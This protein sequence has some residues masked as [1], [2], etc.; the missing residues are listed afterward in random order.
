MPKF[1]LLTVLTAILYICPVYAQS[2]LPEVY[3]VKV[4]TSLTQKLNWPYAQLLEDTTGKL[5]IDDVSAM[6]LSGKF[7]Q[8]NTDKTGLNKRVKFYWQRFDLR[9]VTDRSVRIVIPAR[10]PRTDFYMQLHGGKWKKQTSGWQ[11]DYK[12]RDGFKDEMYVYYELI[13]GQE[14]VFYEHTKVSL[15]PAGPK[16][17]GISIGFYDPFVKVNYIKTGEHF[18]GAVKYSFLFGFM[19]LAA[20]INLIFYFLVKDRLYLYFA[21]VVLVLGFM[22]WLPEINDIFFGDWPY[23]KYTHLLLLCLF[24]FFLW[25]LIN[26]FFEFYLHFP[27]LSKW[28]TALNAL[29]TMAQ[30]LNFFQITVVLSLW[31]LGIYY[32]LL[33]VIVVVCLFNTKTAS[34][35]R[36]IVIMPF[37]L[38]IVLAIAFNFLF[39]RFGIRIFGPDKLFIAAMCCMVA[40]FLWILLDRLLTTIRQGETARLKLVEEQ[41]VLLEAKVTERTIELSTSL[42]SLKSAQRQLI[43]AEKMA[44]LGEL[45]A[46]IAHEIQNPLN[47]INNFSE[48]NTELIEEMNAELK[49]GNIEEGILIASDIEVNM[50]KIN[51]HGKRADA[52]VKGM[53]AHSRTSTGAKE[54]TD[55]NTL[56]D[57]YL[58]LTYH[59]LRAKDKTFNAEL[60]T[61]FDKDIPKISIIPQDI[62]RVLLNLLNNAF[63]AVH[64]QQKAAGGDYRP[65]VSVTTAFAGDHVKVTVADNGVGIPPA[66]MEKIMQPF[67]TT[68]PTGEGTGLGLSLSYDI[69]TNSH[70]GNIGAESMPGEGSKFWFTLPVLK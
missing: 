33:V 45:T 16:S 38:F 7:H 43:Q 25:H 40:A 15:E 51:S 17:I 70:N 12:H 54:L 52:I 3:E 18:F 11:V 46:G 10:A 41:N 26:R 29:A 65:L 28:M 60:E 9:N 59:G 36:T 27:R 56:A 20:V 49:T 62:G 13:P 58:R 67:F 22:W 63:Y 47:F 66:K 4:D 30:V 55:I 37:I 34:R 69:I 6:P 44:S 32:I 61:H 2:H 50:K 1:F 39:A 24:T 57:E 21:I 8:N 53:L 68:K 23:F 31:V 48:V 19:V 35:Q 14:A 5:T 42:E 64:Q